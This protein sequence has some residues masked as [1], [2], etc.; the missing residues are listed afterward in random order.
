VSPAALV[1]REAVTTPSQQG[2]FRQI[3]PGPVGFTP[4]VE[5]DEEEEGQD[6]PFEGESRQ[7]SQHGPGLTSPNVASEP[8]NDGP[9]PARRGDVVDVLHGTPV[10]DPYRW[11]EDGDSPE[12]G[13]WVAE[14][15]RTTRQAL[16]AVATRARWHE[17]LSA[18]VAV[19]QTHVLARRGD[20]LFVFHREGDQPQPALEV[21]SATDPAAARRV[22]F[23][24]STLA[25]DGAAAIDWCSPSRSGDLLAIG[26]SEGGTENSTLHLLDVATAT[27]RTDATDVIPDT[28]AATVAWFPDDSGFWYTRYPAGDEYNR[29]VYRH[30]IGTPWQD[31]PLV[32]GDLPT[33]DAWTSVEAR[34]DGRYLIVSASVGWSR[35]D[36]HLYDVE[37]D[38][39]TTIIEGVEANTSF[40][41][42]GDRLVGTTD[43]DA[44]KA[45]VISAPIAAPTRENWIALVPESDS[46]IEGWWRS[47]S[48]LFVTSLQ[49][50]MRVLTRHA[51]DGTLLQTLELPALAECVGVANDRDRDDV[52]LSL[53]SYTFPTCSWHWSPDRGLVRWGAEAA[54]A[55]DPDNLTVKRVT[56]PSLDGTPIG[57]TVVY[58]T[59][60]PPSA[61]SRCWLTG[62]GGF[63]IATTPAYSSAAVAW[64][65]AGGVFASAGLRGGNEEGE[66]WHQAGM[67]ENKQNVFDDFHAAADF[68]VASKMTSRNTLVVRGGSNG[69]LLMG[70]V[71]TQRP[72][73]AKAIVCEVP[74]LD[75]V[76]FPQFLIAKLWTHEYGDPEV[77]DEFAWIYKYSPY[78]HV[79]KGTAYPATFFV[80]A[81]GDSRVD[82]CHAR[83][84]AAL[85]QWATAGDAP[86]LFKQG[87]RAGHGVGKPV[88]KVVDDTADVFA[89][90]DLALE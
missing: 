23:D 20:R 48:A 56:Y 22:L 64:C 8:A 24:P 73:L 55:F 90:I 57:L 79:H 40:G 27:L 78:H 42:D 18:L 80:T 50:A 2:R 21:G 47:G 81:E 82:P 5:E 84:M 62:Y 33:P 59:D 61:D 39:W 74:L 46:V 38:T 9:P 13:A 31:D 44:P 71:L 51:S 37:A 41:F 67:R 1:A 72:D 53:T 68:L 10:A 30:V 52:H 6:A 17:R 3:D 76:R 70:A 12:T 88:A 7:A 58:R 16:D 77:A 43:L 4:Y 11:L 45:R 69:G 89:F 34:K 85:V 25:E 49:S 15:N 60:A 19:P 75:M 26:I 87:E 66:A 36:Q 86:I 14:Q 29:K 83:K 32:W 63:N 28:R 35:N 54:L 65:E